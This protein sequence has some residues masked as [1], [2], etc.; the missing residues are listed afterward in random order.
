MTL[1]TP[2]EM[3]VCG[4]WSGGVP[5][6]IMTLQALAVGPGILVDL[7]GKAYGGTMHSKI[8]AIGASRSQH[9]DP[10]QRPQ[11]NLLHVHSNH[12]NKDISGYF[13]LPGFCGNPVYH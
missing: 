3:R 6:G 8:V 4:G 1:E 9:A 7:G 13:A 5:V 10:K 11:P 12:L 2:F